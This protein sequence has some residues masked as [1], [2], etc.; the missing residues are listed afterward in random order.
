VIS[1][2]AHWTTVSKYWRHLINFRQVRVTIKF[3]I[4][5]VRMG[6]SG[7]KFLLVP[8]YPGCPGSKAVKRSLL[9][10]GRC[11]FCLIVYLTVPSVLMPSVLW[12][13]WLGVRKSIRPAKI[14]WWGVGV[15]ICLEWGA[16]RLHMVQLTPLPSQ[17]LI[18][19]CLI[20]NQ[21]DFTFLVPTCPGN[22]GKEAVKRV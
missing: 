2:P 1:Q 13:C 7:W 20:W 16:D 6:V 11:L 18:I 14:E 12:R 3:P 19:S 9:L 10:N 15:V 17:N 21:T 22:P 8:A 4:H 5:F